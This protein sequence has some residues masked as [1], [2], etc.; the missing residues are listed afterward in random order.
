MAAQARRGSLGRRAP[1]ER[2]NCAVSAASTSARSPL[3]ITISSIYTADNTTTSATND[4]NNDNANNYNVSNVNSDQ[5]RS[6][7]AS[8]RRPPAG[9][10]ET[11]G[12]NILRNTL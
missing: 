9:D 1:R 12:H 4:H 5:A 7:F 8:P 6:P 3:A 10:V 11:R 2:R